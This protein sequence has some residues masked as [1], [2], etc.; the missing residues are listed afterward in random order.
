MH[1]DAH[2]R[3]AIRFVRGEAFRAD[4]GWPYVEHLVEVAGRPAWAV[5]DAG[6]R[7]VVIGGLI[8]RPIEFDILDQTIWTAARAAFR[9]L[10]AG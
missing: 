4:L 3:G 6:L 2:L 9:R 8:F 1:D 5:D 10:D 7:F